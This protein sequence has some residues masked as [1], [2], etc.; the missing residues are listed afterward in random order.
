MNDSYSG[1]ILFMYENKFLSVDLSMSGAAHV[2]GC[3]D[4][5]TVHN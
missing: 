4:V 5:S 3:L 2:H 1:R